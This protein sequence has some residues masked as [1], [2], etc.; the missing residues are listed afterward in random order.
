MR[1]TIGTWLEDALTGLGP[2]HDAPSPLPDV[3][4]QQERKDPDACRWEPDTIL[5]ALCIVCH[6]AARPE[7][8]WTPGHIRRH[9]TAVLRELDTLTLSRAM[10]LCFCLQR[11]STEKKEANG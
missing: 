1:G 6:P 2:A 5:D 11:L 8:C 9:R 4:F 3:G 7:D 10:M